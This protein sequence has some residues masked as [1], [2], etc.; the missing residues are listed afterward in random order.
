MKSLALVC[1]LLLA[2]AL[3]A[4][5]H[6]FGSYKGWLTVSPALQWQGSRKPGDLLSHGVAIMDGWTTGFGGM[7]KTFG[8][9]G[10]GDL[11]FNCLDSF[12]LNT[13]YKQIGDFNGSHIYDGAS[14]LPPYEDFTRVHRIKRDIQGS[15]DA[16]ITTGHGSA[17]P[18]AWGGD[19][20]IE[21]PEF[22]HSPQKGDIPRRTPLPLPG[23]LK[24]DY[25]GQMSPEWSSGDFVNSPNIC[26]SSVRSILKELMDERILKKTPTLSSPYPYPLITAHGS[27]LPPAGSDE[28][29]DNGDWCTSSNEI[30]KS[31]YCDFYL[32]DVP[33]Y[34][35]CPTPYEK[36]FF[37]R[38]QFIRDRH[39]MERSKSLEEF[40]REKVWNHTGPRVGPFTIDWTNIDPQRPPEPS[41]GRYLIAPCGLDEGKSGKHSGN[42]GFTVP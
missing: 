28:F 2:G 34:Q 35:T 39:T 9:R 13:R 32:P 18:D 15:R 26:S 38:G 5:A 14:G 17:L 24:P 8:P 7:A 6:E 22:I 27:Y 16:G 19:E 40:I 11:P 42:F 29:I 25:I 33:D 3:P 37:P 20:W 10:R 41:S 23:S 12:V 30:E 4:R 31:Q 21:G 36:L 1:T